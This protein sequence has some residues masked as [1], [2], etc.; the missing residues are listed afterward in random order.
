MSTLQEE[1]YPIISK[2]I[3][4]WLLLS[5]AFLF[6]EVLFSLLGFSIVQAVTV[7]N[8]FTV[9]RSSYA[10]ASFLVEVPIL[11]IAGVLLYKKTSNSWLIAIM[12]LFFMFHEFVFALSYYY[13]LNILDQLSYDYIAYLIGL[14]II[15][16][17]SI[18]Y[19]YKLRP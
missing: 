6:L 16:I 1:K 12:A 13:N 9:M 2:L 10:F 4:V 14:V 17:P 11:L 7:D 3:S 15:N 19:L 18:V 8:G 5:G